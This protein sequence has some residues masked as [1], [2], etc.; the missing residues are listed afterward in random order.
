MKLLLL[1]LL[2]DFEGIGINLLSGDGG[3]ALF[4][5]QN[6]VFEVVYLLGN[7]LAVILYHVFG[8]GGKQTVLHLNVLF[9]HLI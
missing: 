9:A 6:D 4:E 2:L 8:D 7:L 1:N 3:M 5:L